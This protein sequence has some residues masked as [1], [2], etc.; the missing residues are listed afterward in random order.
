MSHGHLVATEGVRPFRG[1]L[2]DHATLV[3]CRVKD[4]EFLEMDGFA[5][6]SVFYIS[7]SYMF[8]LYIDPSSIIIHSQKYDA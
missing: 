7:S 6:I 8:I 2:V 4:D 5:V 3:G 1:D